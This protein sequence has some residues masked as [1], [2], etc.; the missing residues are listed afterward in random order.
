MS[1][2]QTQPTSDPSTSPPSSSKDTS[3]VHLDASLSAITA[4]AAIKESPAIAAEFRKELLSNPDFASIFIKRRKGP[5]Y[6]AFRAMEL[7]P[8]IDDM[9]AKN[10]PKYFRVSSFG[11]S[12]DTLR[13]RIYQSFQFLAEDSKITAQFGNR[14][15]ELF[16]RIVIHREGKGSKEEFVTLRFIDDPLKVELTALVAEDG[17]S[18]EDSMSWKQKITDYLEDPQQTKPLHLKELRLTEEEVEQLD[19]SLSQLTTILAKISTS[20]IIIHKITEQS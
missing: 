14:Y 2:E 11:V 13:N 4:L 17:P 6:N 3:Q 20:E 15:A 5:Y 18:K 12:I 9:V 7:K 1:P 19:L 10:K 8:I 16:D